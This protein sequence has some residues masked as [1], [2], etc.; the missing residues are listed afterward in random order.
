MAF[1]N[2]QYLAITILGNTDRHENRHIPNLTG[3]GPF[4]N[5]SVQVQIGMISC[6]RPITP[7]FYM[8]IDLFIQLADGAGAYP[9]PP[10]GPR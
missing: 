8:P 9:G 10:T 6:D 2:S 7:F 1:L 5:D 3:P 4:K